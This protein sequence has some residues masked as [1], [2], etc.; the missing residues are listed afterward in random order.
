MTMHRDTQQQTVSMA[1]QPLDDDAPRHAAAEQT[2][3]MAVQPLDDDA[4][5]HAAAD[6]LNGWATT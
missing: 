5:R 3:S 1:V 2:V 6:C 4:P